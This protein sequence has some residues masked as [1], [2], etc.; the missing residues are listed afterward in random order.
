METVYEKLKIGETWFFWSN[1]IWY[2]KANAYA[3]DYGVLQK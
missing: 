2:E 3:I 1:K